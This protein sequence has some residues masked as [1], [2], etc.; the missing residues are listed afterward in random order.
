MRVP[1][2][3][4]EK[5]CTGDVFE[6]FVNFKLRSQFQHF[7]KRIIPCWTWK[8]TLS[9]QQPPFGLFIHWFKGPRHSLNYNLEVVKTSLSSLFW[10]IFFVFKGYRGNDW[11]DIS[12]YNHCFSFIKKER[13]FN[14]LTVGRLKLINKCVS[15]E[16]RKSHPANIIMTTRTVSITAASNITL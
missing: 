14:F 12:C 3:F 8:T 16:K 5:I 4:Q 10:Q 15:W 7:P 6:I 2:F 9:L 11:S 1:H 13:N